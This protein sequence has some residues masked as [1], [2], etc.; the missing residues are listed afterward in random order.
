MSAVYTL[1][2]T[3]QSRRAPLSYPPI[4]SAITVSD[5]AEGHLRQRLALLR[6]TRLCP[7][8]MF[9]TKS[10]NCLVYSLITLALGIS[11]V[12]FRE[13]VGFV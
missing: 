7:S 1:P 9:G 4:W 6:D 11:L 5:P 10:V 2:K 8:T 13:A 3:R 12:A